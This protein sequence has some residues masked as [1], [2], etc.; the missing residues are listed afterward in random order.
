MES[1]LLLR[2][3]IFKKKKVL[4]LKAD[5]ISFNYLRGEE[6]ARGSAQ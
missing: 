5:E 6:A 4:L 3:N 1:Y 2:I